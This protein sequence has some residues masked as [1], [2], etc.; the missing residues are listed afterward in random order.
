MKELKLYTV[1]SMIN[2]DMDSLSSSFF[3][4]LEEEL[5]TKICLADVT[6][7]GEDEF[8][9]VYIASGGSEIQFLELMK[10]MHAKRIYL[11][12]SGCSNSL[13]AAME[14]LSYINACGM[15]GRILH[16]DRKEIAG[17]FKAILRVEAAKD[18]IKGMRI[19]QV[20]DPSDWLI[21]SRT[22]RDAVKD[23]LGI[24]IVDIPMQELMVEF[25][26]KEY[27]PNCW[28]TQ[29]H[30]C[31]FDREELEKAL[32][33]YGAM[34]RLTE[35]Y[36]LG[37]LSVR[38]FDLLGAIRTTGC[39]G[40][41]VLNAEGTY[42]GCEGDMPSLISMVILGELS[43]RP[44][45]MCNPS[46]IDTKNGEMIFAHCTLPLNMPYKMKLM[47]HFESRIGVAVAGAIPENTITV[48]KAS[49]D[50]GRFY[51]C[52]GMIK[53]NM[54]DD[55]LCRS[56]I[57]VTLPDYR[58]FLE[59]PINNHHLICNGDWTEEIKEFFDALE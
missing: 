1:K 11:L 13:A 51:A 30:S 8:C 22:D 7:A 47:T 37:G 20:G 21:A 57:R 3:A 29:L 14:I 17:R 28:T 24:G 44:V 16:G 42:G 9:I 32:C 5:G 38:C 49:N 40:L 4:E 2:H 27:E 6:D 25:E 19:G 23:L 45:F 59:E 56:Q 18:R 50:L 39:L 36:G 43:G 31:E 26:K 55:T 53:E 58:Y 52:K 10:K 35:R 15:K 54:Q 12:T 48:F 33:L 34:K 41:A 46:R